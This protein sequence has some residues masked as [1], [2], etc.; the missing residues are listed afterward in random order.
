MAIKIIFVIGVGLACGFAVGAGVVAFITVLGII[1]RLMQLTKSMKMILFYEWAVTL[2]VLVGTVFGLQK[3]YLELPKFF[4]MIIGLFHGVFVGML[5]AA[6]Y[7][8][9]NVLPLI[10]KRIHLDDRLLYLLAA[11]VLGK[12]LGSL[13]HWLYFVNL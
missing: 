3:I 10:F 1:P 8:T 13:F 9:I 11:L 12:I 6:L 5:A 4:V 2:G 7:E